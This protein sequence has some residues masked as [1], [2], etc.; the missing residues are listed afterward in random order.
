MLSWL[1]YLLLGTVNCLRYVYVF[2]VSYYTVGQGF[3]NFLW[4]TLY[5]NQKLTDRNSNQLSARAGYC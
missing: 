5:K 3:H 1:H 2:N 4:N